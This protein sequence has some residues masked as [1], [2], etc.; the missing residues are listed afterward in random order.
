M[1]AI[2]RQ[3]E[4]DAT[5]RKLNN[6]VVEEEH[7]EAPNEFLIKRRTTLLGMLG[8][9]LTPVSGLM[10]PALAQSSLKQAA[11]IEDFLENIP[12][13]CRVTTATIEGPYYIDERIVRSDI[14]ETQPGIPLELELR[15]V[16]ANASCK[17]I[18][19]AV[20]S[21]WH[22]NA[23][24]EYS[25][26][27]NNDPSAFPD[28]SAGGEVGHVPEQDAERFLRGVQ[29]TDAEGKVT[30]QTILPGWY[31]PRAVHIHARAF[32]SERDMITT[33]LYFPQA[34]VNNVHSTHE[35]YRERGVSIYT[36]ENDIILDPQEIMKVAVK[37]DGTLFASIT[38]GAGHV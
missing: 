26:Y 21:V 25:G 8:A 35:A 34:V 9:F 29:T 16:N 33:Q 30:F 1:L 22:C 23:D 32:V 37:E 14:R 20:V 13:M 5:M 12:D 28:V 7:E 6:P 27:L 17:P 36:N 2:N 15:L 24:G 38:L 11:E 19:G 4:K 10:S 3:P 18:E 31:T